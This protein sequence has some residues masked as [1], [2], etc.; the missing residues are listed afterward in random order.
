MSMS[1]AFFEMFD[2]KVNEGMFSRVT[3]AKQ[4]SV[5]FQLFMYQN[6]K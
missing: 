2:S 3:S 6:Y 5:V 4:G 1:T